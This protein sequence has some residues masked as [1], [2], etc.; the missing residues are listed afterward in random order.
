[1]TATLRSPLTQTDLIDGR[2]LAPAITLPT[3]LADP[4]TGDV[5]QPQMATA[6]ADV[7]RALR[8]AADLHAAQTLSLI[9][10]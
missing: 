6:P 4:N 5:R 2:W 8:A 10:I 3:A 1:M 9:H 7:E